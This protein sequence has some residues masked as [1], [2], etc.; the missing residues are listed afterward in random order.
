MCFEVIYPTVYLQSEIAN[1]MKA[2]GFNTVKSDKERAVE[3]I[4]T[5]ININGFSYFTLK[6]NCLLMQK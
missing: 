1:L 3:V 6:D 5:W 4:I 2:A